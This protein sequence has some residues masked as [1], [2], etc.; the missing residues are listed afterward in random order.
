M[1]KSLATIHHLDLYGRRQPK[2]DALESLTLSS[3][4]WAELIPANP[5]YFFVPKN[6]DG[7]EEYESGFWVNEIFPVNV[8]GIVTAI[9]KLAIHYTPDEAKELTQ[10]IL[11]SSNPY[12][13]FDI[14]DQRKHKKEARIVELRDAFENLPSKISYRPFD[15]RYMYYTKKTECWINSPRYENMKH[16]TIWSNLWIIS[17]LGHAESGSAPVMITDKIIDFRSWSSPWMQGWDYISPL[18]LYSDTPDLEWNTKTPNLDAEVWW[19]INEIVG[20]TTPENILD[21]IY[22]VLHSPSYREKYKEFL[23]ID[24]P[25]VPYPTSRESF[26]ALIALGG[27]LRALH[28]LESP[29]VEEYITKFPVAGSGEVEKVIFRHPEFISGSSDKKNEDAE[30]SSAWQVWINTTQY[31]GD[32]PEVAW[33]FY[34]GGYQPAQKW[35]KDRKGRVLTWEDISHYQAMIV[36]LTET[37][38]VMGEVDKVLEV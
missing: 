22:A 2:Y 21:Y 1:Q 16:M 14:K 19:K 33:N 10:S 37:A 9:D 18:Y 11:N 28:L 7:Q 29:K 3:I 6:T 13:E 34:I 25:R 38:R 26:L 23:K 36:A 27:E 8:T 35:L 31:F 20:E 24:F 30:T 17:K 5:Y 32:V 4:D 15:T 12:T